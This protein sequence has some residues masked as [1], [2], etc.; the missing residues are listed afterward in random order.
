MHPT[1]IG[2]Y[3]ERRDMH[4]DRPSNSL[5]GIS[6]VNGLGNLGGAHDANRMEQLLVHCATAVESNDATLAQQIMW[7]LNNIVSTEGD[8]NQRVTAYFLRALISRAAR[9]APNLATDM[10]TAQACSTKVLS[11]TELAGFV[12]LTPW[13]RF[14]FSAANGAIL[15]ALGGMSRVHILDFSITHCMQWPTLIE[16]LSTRPEGPPRVR[17]TVHG[18]R[19]QVP[20]LL[21]MTFEELGLKLGNFARSKHVPFQ[22][23]VLPQEVEELHRDTFE[24]NADEA[25]VVNCQMRLHYI[26][27]ETMDPACPRSQFLRLIRSL[28]P[29]IVTLVD[30]DANLTS[31]GLVARLRAAFNYLWIP[32][33]AVDTFLP[34]DSKQRSQYEGD[35]GSKIENIIACEGH[36]RL[37]RLESKETWMQQIRNAHLQIIP[38]SE[39]V[40]AEVRAMLVEYAAGWGLKKDEDAL[41]LTWKGHNV[42]FATACIPASTS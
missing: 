23:R 10:H 27:D 20:P 31:L 4:S 36:Q 25:L 17:L 14:G 26:P 42:V 16:A 24:L 13:H 21:N 40:M 3:R 35:I 12:D 22:F 2:G 1:Y 30:E 37:E 38:F 6:M 19:P 8:P 28:D 5:S 9:M 34:R 18:A 33:D 15:E 39:G 11:A 29:T 32:F 41:L 7:V